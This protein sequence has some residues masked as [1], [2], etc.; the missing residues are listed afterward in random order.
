MTIANDIIA[1]KLLYHTL[2][3]LHF[4]I[5]HFYILLLIFQG[6]QIGGSYSLTFQNHTRENIPYNITA[7]GLKNI[8]L[9]F[10]TVVTAYIHRND[11]TGT[12]VRV[13]CVSRLIFQCCGCGGS[14]DTFSVCPS[15]RLSVRLSVSLSPWTTRLRAVTPG[16][17]APYSD[18]I[19]RPQITT[20]KAVTQIIPI[21][22]IS[23]I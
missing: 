18:A 2:F 1:V 14:G 12:Y 23:T 10:P 8:L 19:F 3:L 15:V 7:L 13:K 11:P 6:N 17:E 16:S 21:A 4:F 20:I 9:E 5:I 22:T